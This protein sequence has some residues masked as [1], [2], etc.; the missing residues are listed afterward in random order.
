M[1]SDTGSKINETGIKTF[2][3]NEEKENKIN[4]GADE[5]F[6]IMI[7]SNITTGF[8]W[9][10]VNVDKNKHVKFLG[11]GEEDCPDEKMGLKGE[12]SY[13]CFVF[14]AVIPGETSI[15]LN[16]SRPWEKNTE[17]LK[18]VKIFLIIH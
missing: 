6:M 14:K 7:K 13:E 11:L 12:S 3:I 8:S 4:I 1:V 15:V 16:F 18:N 5:K 17:P 9:S 2:L 10:P